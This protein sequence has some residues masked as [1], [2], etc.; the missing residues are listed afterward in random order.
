M[1]QES[2]LDRF[3]GDI[4]MY[5]IGEGGDVRYVVLVF[6]RGEYS[7]RVL[8]VLQIFISPKSCML[9]NELV[10]DTYDYLLCCCG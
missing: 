7:I 6:L 4:E 3:I 5:N 1:V 8:R 10:G 2:V 9:V